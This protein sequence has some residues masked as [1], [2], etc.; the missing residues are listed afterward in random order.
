[1]LTKPLTYC[2]DWFPK[3]NESERV[4]EYAASVEQR[5]RE[6]EGPFEAFLEPAKI[7]SGRV[8]GLIEQIVL[9]ETE[10]GY[11]RGAVIIKHLSSHCLSQIFRTIRSGF[12]TMHDG[13][14][15]YFHCHTNLFY[16]IF[17][18]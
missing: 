15:R 13:G 1:M 17:L 2:M 3:R 9:A 8:V 14:T 18:F 5:R 12:Y 6:S 10:H 7:G 11:Q 4:V 16:D